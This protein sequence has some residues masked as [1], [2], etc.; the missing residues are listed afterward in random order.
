M[1]PAENFLTIALDLIPH[2][3]VA[4]L[5]RDF[6][7]NEEPSVAL[8]M[9]AIEEKGTPFANEFGELVCDAADTP[10]AK[11]KF[12]AAAGL[13]NKG[14]GAH[15]KTSTMTDEQKAK[16]AEEAHKWFGEVG[17]WLKDM[18][19]NAGDWLKYLS[20]TSQASYTYEYQREARKEAEE[21]TK[22]TWITMGALLIGLV[23]ICFLIYRITGRH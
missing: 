11:A 18:T 2:D 19:G 9:K 12:R 4:E 20:P 14:T 21:K 23:F 1:T 10:L 3:E 17:G 22:Q 15:T 8:L 16:S 6:G 7:Y 13:V 5:L